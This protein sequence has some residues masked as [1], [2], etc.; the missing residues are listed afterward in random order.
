MTYFLGNFP[1]SRLRRTRSASWIRHL[2]AETYLTAYDLILPLFI[3]HE[4]T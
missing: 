2:T 1:A 3:R 4:E